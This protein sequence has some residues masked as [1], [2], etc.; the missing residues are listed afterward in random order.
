MGYFTSLIF[1]MI[2]VGAAGGVINF[3]TVGNRRQADIAV[4]IRYCLL[5][6]FVTFLVPFVLN[7][8]G[9]TLMFETLRK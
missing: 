5:G 3:Y 1:I 9:S 6:I 8:F 4:L 7:I 2:L